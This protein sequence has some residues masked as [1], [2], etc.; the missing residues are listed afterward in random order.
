MEDNMEENMKENMR[1]WKRTLEQKEKKR[2]LKEENIKY[3]VY[4]GIKIIA[5]AMLNPPQQL[6]L[7]LHEVLNIWIFGF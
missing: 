4:S 1:T 6:E 7:N 3:T 2:I 5:P